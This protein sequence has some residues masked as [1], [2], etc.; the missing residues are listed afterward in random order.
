MMAT[1][2]LDAQVKSIHGQQYY[3]VFGNK[4]LFVEAYP[5]EKRLD[6]HEALDKFVRDY[7]ASDVMKYNGAPEQV[8]PYTKF[9]ANMRKYGI[10]G[11]TAEKKYP[12]RTLPKG[13]SES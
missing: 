2:N 3:Q 5:I 12:I 9:H 1:D 10:K 8:G 13:L 7:G 6:C 11:H 4:D